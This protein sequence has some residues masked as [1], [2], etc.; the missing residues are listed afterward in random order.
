MKICALLF[1]KDFPALLSQ[2]RL[3]KAA[4]ADLVEVRLDMVE[5]LNDIDLLTSFPTPVVISN[6]KIREGGFAKDNKERIKNLLKAMKF[7]TGYVDIETSTLKGDLKQITSFA[8]SNGIRII[9]S[10]HNYKL[11]P[12]LQELKRMIIDASRFADECK[13]MTFARNEKDVAAL[14]NLF[15]IA[16][17]KKLRLTAI[18]LGKSIN[19]NNHI[20]YA[21]IDEIEYGD[22]FLQKFPRIS[23]AREFVEKIA[24]K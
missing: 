10:Y 15:G 14:N 5:N 1:G 22:V 19:K 12:D 13:I 18:A 8:K 21:R 20:I 16:S 7:I 4:G 24:G 11:T 6:R 9:A 2:A 17:A 3:A 23:E